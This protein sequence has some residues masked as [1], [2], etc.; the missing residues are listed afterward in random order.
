[1]LNRYP[2]SF[3]QVRATI[4]G[5]RAGDRMVNAVVETCEARPVEVLISKSPVIVCACYVET[6]PI[7]GGLENGTAF[8]AAAPLRRP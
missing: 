7:E 3:C 1:V 4:V 2:I 6:G 8:S 5:I